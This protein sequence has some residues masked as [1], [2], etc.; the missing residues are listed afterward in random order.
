M[1]DGL[2]TDTLRW[3]HSWTWR[4]LLE[5]LCVRGLEIARRPS[6]PSGAKLRVCIAREWERRDV[7]LARDGDQ[8]RAQFGGRVVRFRVH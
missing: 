8:V 7:S 2:F 1:T 6:T 4:T 5:S 3:W